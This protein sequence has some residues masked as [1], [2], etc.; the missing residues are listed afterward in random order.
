MVRVAV[1][2]EETPH[3]HGSHQRLLWSSV[4]SSAARQEIDAIIV[5]TARRPAYLAG[6]AR[7][8]RELDCT[9]VTLHSGKW[10]SAADA[11]RC[12]PAGVDLI[13]IDVPEPTRLRLPDWETSRELAGTVFARRTDTSAK[14][15]LALM[16]GHMLS[17]SRVLFLDDDMTGL[18]ADDVR[19]ASGLL[20]VYNA[21]GLKNVGFPDNSV[22]CH[23][24][25]DAGGQQ[26]SFIG[27][28]ALAVQI[29]RS[30]SFFPD[31]YNEDWF[32]FLNG[33]KRLQPTAIAGQVVQDPYDPFRNPHRARTEELGDVLAEGIYWLLDQ[34]QSIIDADKDH[35]TTFL[36]RRHQF[37]THVLRMVE[38]SPIEPDDKRRRIA[39]LK[40]SL[41]RLA[42]ITPRLCE[43]YLQAW[44][45]DQQRWHRHLALLPTRQTRASALASLSR[46]GS[47]R[48][49]W[50]LGGQSVDG[51]LREFTPIRM[52]AGPKDGVRLA[53]W[54]PQP[55]PPVQFARISEAG[56]T[57][58]P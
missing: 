58:D 49:T 31:I 48:L 46:R 34:N 33:D 51:E 20:A 50:Q 13:A 52:S 47:P 30:N 6:A 4:D 40:G 5:P 25:R 45:F 7:L 1:P 2:G 41:G 19:E 44:A 8:A 55:T 36:E 54:T 53:R 16:L 12:I 24:Y 43:E 57:A 42:L 23:A 11:A 27:G 10:T 3:H 15:N 29:K 32:F 37:I 35:W 18:K 17:W 21:V 14:R 22:V 38:K 28:G 39:A 56:A 9:L 26:Q